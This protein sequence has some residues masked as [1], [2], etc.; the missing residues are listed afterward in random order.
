MTES[1]ADRQRTVIPFQP[2]DYR[3]ALSLSETRSTTDS[4]FHDFC[5]II[6]EE[7]EKGK[8]H[9]RRISKPVITYDYADQLMT[10]VYSTSN[11]I[12]ART[13]FTNEEIRKYCL[14]NGE[15]LMMEM[16]T[17][18]MQHLISD[19]VWA[20]ACELFELRYI[21]VDSDKIATNRWYEEAGMICNF[22][23]PFNID[24][25]NYI[26]KHY[27]LEDESFGQD[28]IMKRIFWEIMTFIHGSLNRSKDALTLNH[29]KVIHKESIIQSETQSQ[30]PNE[31]WLESVKSKLNNF[32]VSK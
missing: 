16:A 13:T 18:G 1:Q 28:V 19:Q 20:I 7:D 10:G 12:T 23:T 32:G 29:E 24:H 6:R 2:I 22:D 25:L 17:T 15:A 9:Y 3:S 14:T 31:S 30:K 4:I 27:D 5:G 8:L 21:T 11:R 26:K